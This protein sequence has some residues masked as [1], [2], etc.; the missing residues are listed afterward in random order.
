MSADPV[1]LIVPSPGVVTRSEFT[2]LLGQDCEL[3][4][5]EVDVVAPTPRGNL[6]MLARSFLPAVGELAAAG[7]SLVV[8]VGTSPSVSLGHPGSALIAAMIEAR[9]SGDYVIAMD[10]SVA[11]LRAAEVRKVAVIAPLGEQ[12]LTAIG[13]FLRDEGI[14]VAAVGGTG[15]LAVHDVHALSARVAAELAARTVRSSGADCLYIFG[16]G[17]RSLDVLDELR[18]HLGIPVISSNVATAAA[19]RAKLGLS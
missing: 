3:R 14:E 4:F 7:V 16:G 9:Y 1:G 10:A 17:W 5:A 13:R 2:E 6:D 12:M 11:A 15:E 19:V 8:Q 18:G